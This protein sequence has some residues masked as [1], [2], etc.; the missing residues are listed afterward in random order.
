MDR[1][2]RCVTKVEPGV[3][4]CNDCADAV[5]KFNSLLL[6]VRGSTQV[7]VCWNCVATLHRDEPDADDYCPA[8][9]LPV[10]QTAPVQILA[11]VGDADDDVFEDRIDG[12]GEYEMTTEE[13]AAMLLSAVAGPVIPLDY[14]DDVV[15]SLA[16]TDPTP[17]QVA[18]LPPTAVV[19]VA[20]IERKVPPLFPVLGGAL[21][22]L[23]AA[24]RPAN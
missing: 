10:R 16:N 8:C 12:D 13:R 21:A 5:T 2:Y 3:N 23:R 20:A 6:F 4:F 11:E 1:C 22:R 15:A 24:R 14:G 17:E 18:A 19:P 9:G 7:G